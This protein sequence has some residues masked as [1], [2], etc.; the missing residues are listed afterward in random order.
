MHHHPCRFVYHHQLVV[1]VA[2]I[3]GDILRL[4]GS[5]EMRTVEH[6]GDDIA[7]AYLIITLDGTVVHKQEACVGSLL[8]T[9][10]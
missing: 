10:A 7:C 9:V 4:N 3:Q 8:N 1:L 5:I 2:H 6:Q